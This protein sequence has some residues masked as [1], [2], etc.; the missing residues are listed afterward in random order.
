M[1]IARANA[2]EV[3]AAR[4]GI[5][6]LVRDSVEGG[7]SIGFVL[8][9]RDGELDEYVDGV[10]AQVAAGG[11]VV[12]LARDGG[13]VAGMAQLELS[14]KANAQHRAEVQKVVVH[15]DYRGRGLAKRLMA[16]IETTARDLGRTLLVLDTEQGCPAESLY[17]GLGWNEVG[18]I[19]RY[20]GLAH[21]GMVATVVF[22]K[23]L[24]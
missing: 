24:S 2:E 14:P 23:D 9:L 20:A 15:R 1:E 3:D 6:E 5:A 22:F 18:V 10:R 4:D 11:R 17:R 12:L 7:S 13:R 21:G 16:E 19:P 8:P